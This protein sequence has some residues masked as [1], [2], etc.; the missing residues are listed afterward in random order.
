V[1]VASLPKANPVPPLLHGTTSLETSS[2]RHA[3]RT[4]LKPRPRYPRTLAIIGAGIVSVVMA[5]VIGL[6]FATDQ[7]YAQRVLP[8][9]TIAGYDISG[10]TAAQ[11]GAVLTQIQNDISVH[12]TVDGTTKDA[13]GT[14]LGISVDGPAILATVAHQPHH[15]LGVYFHSTT[16]VPLAVAIDKDQFNSWLTRNFPDSFIPATNAGLAY[17]PA[18]NL[19]SVTGSAPGT[20]VAD[21]DLESISRTLAAQSGQASLSTSGSEPVP[22]SILDDQAQSAEQWANQRLLTQCSFSYDD[23]ILYTLTPGDI[24]SLI[25]IA[26]H[27]TGPMVGVDPNRVHDL[28]ATTVTPAIDTAPTTQKLVTD[29]L[30]NTV[31]VAQEGAPGRTVSDPDSLTEQIIACVESGQATQISVAL[32]DVPYPTQSSV[33]TTTPPAGS[34][35]SH[36]ADVNLTTQTVTLMNGSTPGRTLVLSS[37][38][39]AHP[40]PA[41]VFHVYAQVKSQSLSGC[42]DDDCY[43]YPDVHWDTWFYED[44][45]FHEAYWHQEFGTPVS[46]GCL[47]LTYDDALAVFDW[48]SISDAVYIH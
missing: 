25:T 29:E 36:W 37:G 10:M 4:A 41:G 47:N 46:H 9:T 13:T 30:G 19:F 18:T 28:I 24:A 1:E 17:D 38:A 22:P 12:I 16:D 3:V 40:T 11:V 31:A 23:Q 8:T 35:N 6:G 44:Y 48:L 20:G 26:P 27:M 7:A 42:V 34:E 32:V 14:D 15:P 45:G 21:A 43:Y 2:A 33:P 39:P 5:V